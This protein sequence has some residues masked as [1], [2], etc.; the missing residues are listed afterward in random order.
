MSERVV[1]G[2]WSV[3]ANAN[4]ARLLPSSLTTDH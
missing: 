1:S 3:N 2:Q 4:T